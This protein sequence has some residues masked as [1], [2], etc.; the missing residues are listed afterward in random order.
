[1]AGSW[2]AGEDHSTPVGDLGPGWSASGDV[3]VRIAARRL[4]HGLAEVEESGANA[5]CVTVVPAGQELPG[6]L[7]PP[8]TG[9]PWKCADVE[10]ALQVLEVGSLA[11][12]DRPP[13]RGLREPSGHQCDA[14]LVAAKVA[15]PA[16]A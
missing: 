4:P 3:A 8:A 14:G 10:E 2:L 16:V 12:N 15:S 11:G 1:M 6:D 7:E 13:G 5:S 9:A